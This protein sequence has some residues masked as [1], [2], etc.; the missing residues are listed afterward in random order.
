MVM[1]LLLHQVAMFTVDN[2]EMIEELK[3]LET[4]NMQ[5]GLKSLK[6]TTGEKSPNEKVNHLPDIIY[7]FIYINY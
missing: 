2:S 5:M 1:E 7:T 6:N 3:A 4:S